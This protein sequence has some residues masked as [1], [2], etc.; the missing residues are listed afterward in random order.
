MPT[1][2]DYDDETGDFEVLDD[3]HGQ[4]TFADYVFEL[5]FPSRHSNSNEVMRG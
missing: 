5:E 3:N 4:R 1:V 2:Y